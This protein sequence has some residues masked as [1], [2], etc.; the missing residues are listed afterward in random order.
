[1]G[2]STGRGLLGGLPHGAR[3]RVLHAGRKLTV[4]KR[5]CG[6]GGGPVGGLPR[7]IDLWWKAAAYLRVNGLAVV[8]WRRVT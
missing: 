3:I 6:L 2:C 7:S 1:M 4:V 5:D 8:Q